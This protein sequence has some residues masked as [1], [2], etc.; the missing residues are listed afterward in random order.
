[1][2]NELL[3]LRQENDSLINRVASLESMSVNSQE[4]DALLD[5]LKSKYE[6]KLV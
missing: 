6:L 3:L 5:Q 2:E 4:K 1:M